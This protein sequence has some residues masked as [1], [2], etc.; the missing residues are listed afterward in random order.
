MARG[1]FVDAC[2]FDCGRHASPNVRGREVVA[3]DRAAVWICAKARCREHV[4]PLPLAWSRW[5]LGGEG[6]W[7]PDTT[8]SIAEIVLVK[9]VNTLHVMGEWLQERLREHGNAIF[10]A[11]PA[12]HDDLPLIEFYILH[13]QSKSFREAQSGT[14]EQRRNQKR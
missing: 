3:A 12:A 14:V 10:V 11:L 6:V 8:V 5:I 4:L 2:I 1:M 9:Q 13:T 7:Q